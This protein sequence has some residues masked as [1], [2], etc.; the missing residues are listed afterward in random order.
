VIAH[1]AIE[2]EPM[3]Q[4]AEQMSPGGK[5]T[6]SSMQPPWSAADMRTV[7]LF[8][9]A[10]VFFGPQSK[11]TPKNPTG[12]GPTQNFGAVRYNAGWPI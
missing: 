1:R 6:V 3:S 10:M 2:L 11:Q 5:T 12:V 8:F 4:C 9:G 7:C